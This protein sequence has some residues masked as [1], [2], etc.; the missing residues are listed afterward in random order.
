MSN[1]SLKKNIGR[2]FQAFNA[3]SV[4]RIINVRGDSYLYQ[5]DHD[6]NTVHTLAAHDFH[7]ITFWKVTK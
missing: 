6:Q 4:G 5:W 1:Q 2:T 3:N 7:R